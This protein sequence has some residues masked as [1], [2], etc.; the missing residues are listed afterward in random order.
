MATKTKERESTVVA[1]ESPK[2]IRVSLTV[3]GQVFQEEGESVLECIERLNPTVLKGR[4]LVTAT[5][6][7][8]TH[9]VPLSVFQLRRLKVNKISKLILAKRL[10]FMLGV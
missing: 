6:G 7:K 3:G 1:K 9:T 4:C 10:S 8:E 2:T 5:N